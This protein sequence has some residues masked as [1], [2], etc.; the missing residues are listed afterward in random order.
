MKRTLPHLLCMSLLFTSLCL[1]QQA[2]TPAPAHPHAAAAT[3]AA[4]PEA[5]WTSLMAGN[6]RYVAG[7]PKARSLVALRQSLA[8]DQHPKVA[9]LACADSRVAPEIVFDQNLGDLFVVRS[10]GNIADAIGLGS[11]EYAVEH[12]GSTVVVV[13]GHTGCGA[14]KAACSGD[15]MPTANLQA[16]VDKIAP[17]VAV[18]KTQAQG[19]SLV[20]TAVRDN[21]QQSAKDLVDHS[22]VLQHM[23]SDGRITLIEAVYHLDTG[24]VERVGK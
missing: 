24:K 7:H 10:A 5:I 17:A 21:V 1:A 2:P 23:V 11:L 14:V 15:K 12:L 8:K 13:M 18:A 22:E 19:D 3:S 4:S 6:A 16:I 9:V 20:D